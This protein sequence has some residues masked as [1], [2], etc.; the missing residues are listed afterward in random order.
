M[1]DG[2]GLGGVLLGV[3]IG[4]FIWGNEP[5]YIDN[6]KA[7]AAAP[8]IGD[9]W[10]VAKRVSGDEYQMAVIHDLLDNRE[11]CEVVRSAIAAYKGA[12]WICSP[13]HLAQGG[14][15]WWEFW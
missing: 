3:A 15:P 13:A 8:V 6:L 2:G 10:I 4:Y 12:E 11:V 7:S 14:K 1:S 9:S 5:A